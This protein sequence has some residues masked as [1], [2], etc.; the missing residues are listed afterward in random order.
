MAAVKRPARRGEPLRRRGPEW[1]TRG[2]VTLLEV[3][4]A[5][6]VLS[7]GLLGL[8][9]LIP[10]GR[11]E[12]AEAGKVDRGSTLGRAAFRDLLVRGYL[13]PE[14][15]LQPTANGGFMPV[16]Q[17]DKNLGTVNTSGAPIRAARPRFLVVD[18]DLVGPPVGPLVL[19]PLL[20][21]PRTA[22]GSSSDLRAH[23]QA[24]R[25][26]PY[27][28]GN[29]KEGWPEASAPRI[30][31]ITLRQ[32]PR[33]PDP[34]EHMVAGR[35]FQAND[36]LVFATPADKIQRPMQVFQQQSA[37][38]GVTLNI[39]DTNGVSHTVR[40]AYRQFQGDYSWLVTVSPTLTELFNLSELDF[41]TVN[42][43]D[44]QKIRR[45]GDA[46]TA[47]Q[48][49]VTV[50]IF[51]KRELSD[52]TTLARSNVDGRALPERMCW[53]DFD[54]LNTATARLRVHDMPGEIEAEKYLNVRVNQ[55]I[56]LSGRFV[57]ATLRNVGLSNAQVALQWYR[58]V[59]VRGS[60][61]QDD[62]QSNIWYRDVTLQ[63]R[64]WFEVG[65]RAQTP[66]QFIDADG[67]PSKGLVITA[68]GTIL[69][70][71]IAVYEKTMTLDG[72]SLWSVN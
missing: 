27:V 12:M 52:I 20:V 55:W 24:V 56:A 1:T 26:F 13:R 51:H 49:A 46:A 71:V 28:L 16:L 45:S 11:F 62:P 33:L 48:Y 36:D 41:A 3:L 58:V 7:V 8:A 29:P 14:N 10:V 17:A 2:G 59:G 22:L 23:M 67:D 6:M 72:V 5:I 54:T 68:Y 70:G 47:R 18:T 37:A 60:V 15:W 30:A 35:F 57:N 4:V 21:V 64:P 42:A 34:M 63:G 66:V 39:L 44:A 38:S 32:M 61:Y 53:V 9:A 43:L 25:R 31:R 40:P 65:T 50:V 19:D 69:D